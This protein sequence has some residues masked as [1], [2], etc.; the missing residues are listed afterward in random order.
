VFHYLRPDGIRFD[1]LFPWVLF[2]PPSRV[3]GDAVFET[4][5]QATSF[6]AASPLATL[7]AFLGA[8]WTIRRPP[9][10]TLWLAPLAGA[11]VG[12]VGTFS[13][14]FI[15]QRYQGD[16]APLLIVAATIGTWTAYDHLR[17][18]A[19][20]IAI[21]ATTVA[22]VLLAW[23]TWANL[24]TAL[25]YQR[26]QTPYTTVD[27]R[28]SL[29]KTQL[30]L[31][32]LLG[33]GLPSNVTAG[34]TLPPAGAAPGSLFVVG[35]CAGLYRSEGFN[36]LSVEQTPTTGYHPLTLRLDPEATGRQPVL[37]SDD[38]LGTSVIWATALPDDRVALEY[39]WEPDDATGGDAVDLDLGVVTT[40]PDGSIELSAR[41]DLRDGIT[42]FLQLRAEGRVLFDD[43]VPRIEGPIEIGT[44]STL[45]GADTFAGTI[46]P[47]P[48][49]TPLCDRLVRMGL[50]LP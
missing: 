33:N 35:D 34:T 15:D 10:R 48:A 49:P 7:L 23:S 4:Q 1:R 24:A 30:A 26:A 6:T 40:P 37:S 8:W 16:I 12:A 14:A 9:I 28:A 32:D 3:I 38:P 31:H 11:A 50:D 41:F 13:L 2:P 27:D 21:A 43:V 22:V 46:E 47:R 25:V 18:H 20:P 29:V 36:W 42:N 39:Q 5:R 19:R 17:R 44:Q 45:P